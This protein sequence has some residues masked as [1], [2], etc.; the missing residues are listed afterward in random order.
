MNKT[1]LQKLIVPVALGCA[2]VLL[3]SL[4]RDS[5][6]KQPLQSIRQARSIYVSS[7]RGDQKFVAR[8]KNEMR[9]MGLRFISQESDADA[10]MAVAGEYSDGEFYG[11]L[12]FFNSAGKA[13]WKAEA[14]R[15]RGSSYMAYS[16]L[17]DQLRR[18]M[19]E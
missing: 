3:L 15:P 11:Q 2:A 19:K 10:I 4:S 13:I 17:A 18:A 7:A 8:L 6:A 1:R 14:K 9:D 12:K 16:R 5:A